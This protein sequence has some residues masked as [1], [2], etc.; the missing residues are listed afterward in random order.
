V[1][2]K[3]WL[4]A[5]AD[6]EGVPMDWLHAGAGIL[7]AITLALLLGWTQTSIKRR[8]V[9]ALIWIGAILSLLVIRFFDGQ[10]FVFLVL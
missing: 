1:I 5:K 10:P 8:S 3:P 7:I 2:G 9:K 4:Y 6:I